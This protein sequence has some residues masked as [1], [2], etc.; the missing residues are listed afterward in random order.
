MLISESKGFANFVDRHHDYGE[1]QRN[2]GVID[3]FNAALDAVGLDGGRLVPL[4]LQQRV[5]NQFKVIGGSVRRGGGVGGSHLYPIGPDRAGDACEGS[6]GIEGQ[7]RG[8]RA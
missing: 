5:H 6:L 7:S 4:D 8:K 3:N 1:V 2:M